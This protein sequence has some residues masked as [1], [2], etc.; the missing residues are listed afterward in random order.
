[1]MNYSTNVPVRSMVMAF[2]VSMATLAMLFLP[3]SLHLSL[4]QPGSYLIKCT[5]VHK[6]CL[7]ILVPHSIL[8]SID[9]IDSILVT[10]FISR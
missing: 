2:T 7:H 5:R 6:A 8:D 3:D 9:N 10:F 4:S 1:M